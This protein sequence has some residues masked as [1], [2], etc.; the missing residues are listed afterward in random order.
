MSIYVK[1]GYILWIKQS[2]GY[3]SCMYRIDRNMIEMSGRRFI[4]LSVFELILKYVLIDRLF[5]WQVA[6]S[7][8]FNSSFIKIVINKYDSLCRHRRVPHNTLRLSLCNL[9]LFPSYICIYIFRLSP[10][11]FALAANKAHRNTC[12]TW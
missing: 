12:P 6:S 3:Y 1:Q 11:K 5:V 2:S 9:I 4:N 8:L 10:L 7:R